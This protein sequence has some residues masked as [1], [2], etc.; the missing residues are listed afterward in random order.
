MHRVLLMSRHLFRIWQ[1][2][3]LH[4]SRQFR[5]EGIGEEHVNLWFVWRLQQRKLNQQPRMLVKQLKDGWETKP[6]NLR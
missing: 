3:L 2:F 5:F 4:F 1:C 6:R